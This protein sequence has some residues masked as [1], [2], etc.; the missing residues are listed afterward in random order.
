MAD[1]KPSLKEGYKTAGCCC[2]QPDDSIRGYFSHNN[3]IVIHRSSCA[4]LK[5]V[6]SERLLSLA[7]EEILDQKENEPDDDYLRLDE[8]DFDI[9]QHHMT[10]GIDYSLMV[11]NL[12]K[13]PPQEVFER[14]RKLKNLRLLKRVE[15]VM[16]RY[17]KGIVDNKWI[18]HRNHTYYE[19]TPKGERYLNVFHSRQ[20]GRT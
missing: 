5:K 13:V 15:G 3:L 17:R 7:W 4:S 19:I 11:A 20:D 10:M 16:V 2:P 18:K 14:H 9:L 6:E 12:L 1:S 8:L